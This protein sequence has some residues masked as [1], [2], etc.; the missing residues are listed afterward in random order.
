[1]EKTEAPA[2]ARV[3]PAVY[4][5]FEAQSRGPRR[6]QPSLP[7]LGKVRVVAVGMECYKVHVCT[8]LNMCMKVKSASVSRSVVSDSSQPPNCTPPGS[9][10]QRILQAG[11]LEWV[12]AHPPAHP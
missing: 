7:A 10:V 1:M 2:Y 6:L 8:T 5:M 12:A 4:S 9:S 11:I 3:E